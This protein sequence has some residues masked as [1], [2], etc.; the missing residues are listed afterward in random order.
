MP[1]H[2]RIHAAFDRLAA[3]EGYV[4]RPDQRQLA[5]LIADCL[6]EDA[7]GLFEAPTGLGK[8]LAALVPAIAIALESGK[9]TVV[10]TYTNVL[11]EQYWNQD[12]PL[13]L[14]LFDQAPRCQYLVGRQQYACV[15]ALQEKLP[16]AVRPMLG[17]AERGTEPEFR[18]LS[19][20][21][22]R[23]AR[24]IW[25]EITTPPVCPAR[26]CP[27]FNE[28]FYYAARRAA[29]KAEIVLTNHAMVLQDAILRRAS[30]GGL[31]LLGDLGAI[32]L[33]EA[34]DFPQAAYGALDFELSPHSLAMISGLSGRL[35][36]ALGGEADR[37]G[38]TLEW[39]HAAE[40]MRLKLAEQ[41]EGLQKLAAVHR[42][43]IL[44][45]EPAEVWQ[46]PGVQSLVVPTI[47][48][49]CS[50]VASA[51]AQAVGGYTHQVRRILRQWSGRTEEEGE[52]E[53]VE[54]VEPTPAAE[55]AHNYLMFLG[56]YAHGCRSLLEPQ[57]VSVA[58]AEP[59]LDGVSLKAQA[60]DLVEPLRELIWDQ[61]PYV[62]LSATLALDGDF[63]HF[64]RVTGAEPRFE[65]VL[66]SPFDFSTQAAL[67]LPKSGAI[68]DPSLARKEGNEDAYFAA[69]AGELASLMQVLGGRTLAL[70]HS[71]RE[72]ESVYALMEPIPDL[73]LYIQSRSGAAS[74]GERFKSEVRSSLFALRS[75]W[76]GFDAPGET[77]SC[78]AIVRVPFE[79][80]VDPAQ[81]ARNAYLASKGLDGF[82]SHSLPNA[83]MLLRQGVGR[84][85][86]RNEDKGI[87]AIL[88]PRLRT[89]RY[90]EEI[91]ANLPPG[92]RTFDDSG[93]AAAWVGLAVQ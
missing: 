13:A 7:P 10:A 67:Y 66:P 62:G 49:Q 81:I 1:L 69:I 75:F 79:V 41:T 40:T 90:G 82:R 52:D 89:K 93:E 65:E 31:A 83:K 47:T 12:L 45:A 20:L 48:E 3:R 80:P 24:K 27:R 87:I 29:E 2:D 39:V 23:E 28:C 26:L 35:E 76:T 86:R 68:P 21:P 34:H 36:Q 64:K 56:E 8:S 92:M 43:H 74:V 30:E 9:R 19:G 32:I 85:I 53:P 54:G 91:L 14:S 58:Y 46:S 6:E 16:A 5:L 33:D 63:G 71:R 88:D 73:P 70:F 72:M 84:L 15:V 17:Q 37:N 60:V 61:T 44:A 77:L 42:S 22:P 59:N 51:V 55:T 78:V 18:A 57:G 38:D 4:E 50:D 11:A 25:P